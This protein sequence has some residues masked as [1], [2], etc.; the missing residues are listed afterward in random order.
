MP[1]ATWD[2]AYLLGLFNRLAGRPS[3]DAI[4]D[5]TKYQ[6]LSEAQNNVIADMVAVTPNSLY[7]T[8]PYASLPTLTTTDDQIY[9]FGTD[10]NGYPKF[11]MN[12]QIFANL[13]DI[14]T[15]P[16]RPNTDYMIEGSQIR[17]LNNGTLPGTLYV[18]G[19]FQP[20]DIN[21]T[22]QPTLKPE[23]S[24]ELIAIRAA[25]NFATEGNRNP[26]LAETM[27]TRYGY[28][29]SASPAGRFPYWCLVWKT[30]FKGGGVLGAFTGRQLAAS[31]YGNYQ[32]AT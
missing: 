25:Y 9:T 5:A 2:S 8:A 17:A 14:P 12:A 1:A 3:S 11:P 21:A 30:Q 15:N 27:A 20:A 10:A 28:P 7:P 32:W 19:I 4:L 29:L 24:R 16:L 26:A 31:G 23:P 6:M 22:D 18:Y 13:T